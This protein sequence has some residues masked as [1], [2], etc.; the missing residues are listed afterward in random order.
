MEGVRRFTFLLLMMLSMLLVLIVAKTLSGMI[1]RRG[2]HQEPRVQ[3]QRAAD[4][5]VLLVWEVNNRALHGVPL[6]VGG[7]GP[8]LLDL[9]QRLLKVRDK[10]LLPA[11]GSHALVVHRVDSLDTQLYS[12]LIPIRRLPALVPLDGDIHVHGV[13]DDGKPFDVADNSTRLTEGQLRI[14]SV[15]T[16]GTATLS[17]SGMSVSLRPGQ[18]WGMGWAKGT[19]GKRVIR[20]NDKWAEAVGQHLKA[21]D[22]ITVLTVINF[23]RWPGNGMVSDQ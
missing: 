19:E 21:G 8:V 5:V 10:K 20:D 14:N 6:A 4:P 16:D 3:E 23:G 2:A 15:N 9:R 22:T 18:S 13:T 11:A 17:Y 1:E 12:R 7:D